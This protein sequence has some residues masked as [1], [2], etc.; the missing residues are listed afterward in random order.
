MPLY[1]THLPHHIRLRLYVLS[2]NSSMHHIVEHNNMNNVKQYAKLLDGISIIMVCNAF[3][4]PQHYVNITVLDIFA[5]VLH[6]VFKLQFNDECIK[7]LIYIAV[8]IKM[9][10]ECPMSAIP[11]VCGFFGY[12]HNLYYKS[13]NHYNRTIWH[14]GN[15][16]FIGFSS[17]CLHSLEC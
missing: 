12:L 7:K 5:V 16:I 4:L 13:W 9:G 6:A 15:A 17:N 10:Y 11:F 8:F 14:A 3:L 1:F 2:V